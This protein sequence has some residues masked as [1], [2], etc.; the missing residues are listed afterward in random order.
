MKH[1][2]HAQLNQLFTVPDERQ[3]VSTAEVARAIGVTDR[4]PV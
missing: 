3:F 2:K 4:S 1:T